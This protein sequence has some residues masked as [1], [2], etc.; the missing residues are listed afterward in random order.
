MN[1]KR[2]RGWE[3][4][5]LCFGG[6]HSEKDHTSRDKSRRPQTPCL[7][8]SPHEAGKMLPIAEFFKLITSALEKNA[9]DGSAEARDDGTALVT[10][11]PGAW[12]TT[13]VQPQLSPLA[14]STGR[15]DAPRPTSAVPDNWQTA[16]VSPLDGAGPSQPAD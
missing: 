15:E 13:R 6:L 1:Y 11:I 16:L 2:F 4:I 7:Q 8:N 5:E 10:G 14:S 12:K 3:P 9:A